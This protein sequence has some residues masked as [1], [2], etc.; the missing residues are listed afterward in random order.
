MRVE[1]G[2]DWGRQVELF[3]EGKSAEKIQVRDRHGNVLANFFA[4]SNVPDSTSF[5]LMLTYVQAG[6]CR[7]ASRSGMWM[8]SSN[9]CAMPIPCG[10]HVL[11]TPEPLRSKV[12]HRSP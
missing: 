6:S 2:L 11:T 4:K 10:I 12:Q 3:A 8:T 9:R 1:Y 7:F 5:P